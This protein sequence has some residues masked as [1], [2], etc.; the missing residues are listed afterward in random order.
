MTASNEIRT[1]IDSYVDFWRLSGVEYLADCA[2][3][4]WFELSEQTAS[5]TSA[6]KPA[7]KN[8]EKPKQN[9][10]PEPAKM[11]FLPRE[12]WPDDFEALKR[13]IA[14]GLAFPGNS[15]GRK[16]ALP[17]G[18]L[19]PKLLIV[20]DMPEIDDIDAGSLALGATAR[21]ASAMAQAAGIKAE[22]IYFTALATTR[23]GAGALPVEMREELVTFFQHCVGIIQPQ[24]ILILGPAAAQMLLDADFMNMR[25]TLQY[26]NH[27][28]G[29][30]AAVTTFHPRTLLKNS[31]LKSVAWQDLQ[32]FAK[33]GTL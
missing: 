29:K 11:G 26:I 18:S 5:A 15:F 19:K 23:P 21:I 3:S 4:N 30:V 16:I 8:P 28:V 9:S 12:S 31:T 13:Q 6:A 2:V 1:C 17:S 24:M 20:S 32:I 33:K 14:D 22:E 7:A 27:D 10:I 25:G